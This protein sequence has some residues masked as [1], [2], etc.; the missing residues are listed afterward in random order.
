MTPI[1]SWAARFVGLPYA[2]KGRGPDAW[3]CWGGARMV[4]HDVFG[5]ALPDYTDAYTNADDSRS[6]AAAVAAGL[7]SGWERVQAPRAGDLLIL[8]IGGRPWHCAVLVTPERFLHWLPP[9]PSGVQS[10]SCIER[11]DSPRWAKRIDG[12]WRCTLAIESTVEKAA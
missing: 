5:L 8:R 6:V 11:L 2:D 9:A 4:L 7:E 3:D 10:F 12:F 1:P